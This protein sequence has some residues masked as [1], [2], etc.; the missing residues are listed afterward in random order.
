MKKL[1][2]II[3]TLF[4]ST[5]AFAHTINWHAGD[6]IISTTTCSSGDNITPPT[7]PAKLG[8]HFKEWKQNLYDSATRTDNKYITDAGISADG[9][10]WCISDYIP[11]SAGTYTWSFVNNFSDFYKRIAFYTSKS[12]TNIQSVLIAF[13][14]RNATGKQTIA[15]SVPT[16]GYIRFGLGITDANVQFIKTA[17][18]Q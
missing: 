14:G 2:V 9:T 1:L 13:D 15:V 10:G 17:P 16:D 5:F 12:E 6:Q 11:V 3:G 18:L 4:I 7:A 8:Y